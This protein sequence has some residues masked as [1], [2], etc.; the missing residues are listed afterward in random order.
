MTMSQGVTTDTL[1]YH[2]GKTPHRQHKMRYW[3]LP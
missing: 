1:G 3:Y 2:T